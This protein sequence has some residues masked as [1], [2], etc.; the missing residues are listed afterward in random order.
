MINH[1]TVGFYCEKKI[2]SNWVSLFSEKI[3]VIFEYHIHYKIHEFNM[4]L[5]IFNFSNA[6]EIAKLRLVT[7]SCYTIHV[8]GKSTW[9][10]GDTQQKYGGTHGCIFTDDIARN[11]NSDSRLGAVLSLVTSTVVRLGLVVEVGW[12]RKFISLMTCCRISG[13]KISRCIKK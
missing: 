5:F 12:W 8:I 4:V 1:C 11:H 9:L 6:F 10:H 3:F 2:F 7:N 13:T